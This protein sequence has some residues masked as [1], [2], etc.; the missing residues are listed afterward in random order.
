MWRGRSQIFFEIDRVVAE[1]GLG[2]RARASP[3][4]WRVRR[5]AA[6]D[7]HA[8]SAAAGRRL[9]QHRIAD[10]AG[11]LGGFRVGAN[12]AI[13]A[14]HHRNAERLGGALGLDL[15]AHQAD[16]L[17]LRADEVH[18]VLG[19]DFGKARVLRQKAVAGMH[20][21]GAGDLAG[22]QNGRNVEIA[23]LGR[24]AGRCTR[25]RRR[26]AHA[27]RRRRRWNAPPRSECRAPCRRAARAARSR[28]DW[29]SGFYRTCRSSCPSC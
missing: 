14:R 8:A 22:R 10:L 13:R 6:H 26:S 23:V 7:L 5:R 25:S 2:F 20:G 21:V 29:R 9:D 17:G 11:D 1:G 3:A 28:R 16:M 12:A 27:W 19:E 24:P 4:R 18:A 15:V